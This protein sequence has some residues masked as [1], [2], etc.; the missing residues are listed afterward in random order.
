MNDRYAET[1]SSTS[2]RLGEYIEIM[3]ETEPFVSR[4]GNMVNVNRQAQPPDEERESDN[5]SSRQS[6]AEAVYREPPPISMTRAY[7]TVVILFAINLLNYMDRYTIAANLPE[8]QEFFKLDKSNVNSESGLLQT[9]FIVGYMVTSPVFGYLGDRYSRKMI[10]IFG[11]C[12]WSGSTLAGSFVP[13]DKYSLFLFMRAVVGVGEASYTTVASTIIADLFTGNRR[14]QMLMLFYFAIPVGSGLGYIAGSGIADLFGMWQAAFRVTPFLGVVSVIAV[15]LCI[16]EPRRGQAESNNRNFWNTS[17]LDD[18]KAL[19]R[20]RSWMWSSLGFV[21]VAWVVGALSLWAPNAIKYAYKIQGKDTKNVDFLFGG[22]TCISGFVGVIIGTVGAQW[23]RKYNPRADPLVCAI[24]LIVGAPFLYLGLMLAPILDY[25]AWGLILI[26]EI[27]L[28]LNWALVPD[29][30][31]YVVLPTRR[32]TASALQMLMG[33]ALGDALSPWIIG[34][35][36]DGIRHHMDLS[37]DYNNFYS[38]QYALYITTFI[39]VLGG[40]AFLA[41]ALFIEQDKLRIVKIVTG[42]TVTGIDKSTNGSLIV[43]VDVPVEDNQYESDS[44]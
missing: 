6:S 20:N 10:L 37:E 1:N 16:R 32:A 2:T 39:T 13:S 36:S 29:I 15:I 30:L 44:D 19:K 34:A 7:I 41:N 14:T 40:G 27:L 25:A 24:G 35:I 28:F 4:P 38:L 18:L 42:D 12:V 33:H 26:A 5:G 21:S 3:E 23:Y 22:I 43:P 31:L 9:V 17:Y 8:I 11:I